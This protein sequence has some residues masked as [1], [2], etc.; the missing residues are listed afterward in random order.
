M[1]KNIIFGVI[2]ISALFFFACE[3][4]IPKAI[5]VKGTPSVRFA[6][7]VN[8][9]D[10]FTQVLKDEIENNMDSDEMEDV[11]MTILPCENTDFF[12]FIIHMELFNK[13][14]NLDDE[15]PQ[16]DLPGNDLDD[17]IDDLIQEK[18]VLLGEDKDLIFLEE[19]M[20]LPLS[21]IGSLLDG[22]SFKE[23][24]TKLYLSGTSI[25]DK[26]KI[27]I[28]IDKIEINENDE[29]ITTDYRNYEFDWRDSDKENK[30]SDFDNWKDGYTALALPDGGVE[31]EFPAD[32]KNTSV[33]FRVV[34]PEGTNLILSDFEDGLINVEVVVWLPFVLTADSDGAE[35]SFPDGALFSAEDDLFGR[36]S[37]DDENLMADI[38]ENMYLEIKL[39]QN[40][41]L[42]SDLVVWSENNNDVI[43]ITNPLT[44]N[45]LSFT[46]SDN[47][48][49]K[50]NEPENWPFTPNFKMV[51]PMGAE[52]SF[53]REFNAL[54]F[55]FNAKILY[56]MDF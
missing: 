56:R 38:I 40:P 48:M 11:T 13:P 52:L 34:I 16:L 25:V 8:I 23:I 50:I 17:F 29:E 15:N 14:I 37:P 41:F 45:S 1:R 3:F 2:A 9:G 44:T 20:I 55:I 7:T 21:S 5:E 19:P 35:I 18:P 46:I 36:S 51:F 28:D 24:K 22:F 54:E 30:N 31:I 53:P 32:G 47:D 43:I 26:L 39:D 33:S 6:Q 12:T 27:Y 42:G 49:K 10:M 4:N